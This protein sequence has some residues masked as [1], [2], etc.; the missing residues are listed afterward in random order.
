MEKEKFPPSYNG[1]GFPGSDTAQEKYTKKASWEESDLRSFLLSEK[2]RRMGIF[3]STVKILV[4]SRFFT[5]RPFFISHLIT[6]R[7]F[8]R[9]P[10]CLWRGDSPEEEDTAK[11]VD[12]YRRARK[13]GF[14]STTFWGGEPLLRRDIIDILKNCWNFGFFTGLITNGY[15]L[16]RFAPQLA[17][18]LA[19][20]IVSVDAPGQENDRLRGVEGLYDLIVSGIQQIKKENPR[21]KVFINSVI[22]QLNFGHVE[23]LIGIAETLKM[24]ITFEAVKQGEVEFPRP[25]GK[26]VVSLRLSLEKEKEIFGF[27]QRLKEKHRSIN[28]SK[29]Y[30]E[31]FAS[32]K[33]RYRCHAPKICIRVEPDG[34]ITNCLDQTHPLGN[35]YREDLHSIL[36]SPPMKRL[37]KKAESC[38]SCVDTGAIESSLFWDFCPEVMSNTFLFFLK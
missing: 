17:R 1:T 34:R 32:G 33:V 9:C 8:A 20:L 31:L 19:Y 4:Q 11:V 2:I 25:E 36:E 16:P 26:T 13:L 21:L 3:L 29:S 27:I 6:T 37:Q 14:V 38:S 30:L 35:V 5:H 28:N 15:F 24:G 7:C 22:S 12:F 18:F 23:A 10:T